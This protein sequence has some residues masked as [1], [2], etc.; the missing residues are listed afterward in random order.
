MRS[1][2]YNNYNYMERVQQQKVARIARTKQVRKQ[3]MLLAFGIILTIFICTLFTIKAFAYSKDE[4]PIEYGSK[5]YKSVVIYCG[6]SIESIAEANYCEA[7]KNV[8]EYKKEILNINHLTSDVKLIP[9][10]YIIIPYYTL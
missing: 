3:K 7:Y 5:Q 8:N 6:D 9:G 2:Y 10:N 1:T 4:N